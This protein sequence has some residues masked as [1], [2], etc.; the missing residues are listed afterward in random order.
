MLRLGCLITAR[1]SW[2]VTARYV[3][4]TAWLREAAK[5]IRKCAE[6]EEAAASVSTAGTFKSKAKKAILNAEKQ[7]AKERAHATKQGHSVNIT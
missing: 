3:D 4:A 6:Y 2:L 1:L 5:S 7:R